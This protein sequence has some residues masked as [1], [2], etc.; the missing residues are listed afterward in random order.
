M[1]IER[2]TIVE[3]VIALVGVGVFIAITVAAGAMSNGGTGFSET[4]ALTL[5]GG[6]IAFVV[7][8]SGIGFYLSTRE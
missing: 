6:M 1:E 2:E 4:G 8:M 3:A 5:V 7:V